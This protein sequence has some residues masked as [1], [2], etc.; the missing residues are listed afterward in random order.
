M[1][2]IHSWVQGNWFNIIQTAGIL[3]SLWLAT[4]A[5]NREAKA[6]EIQNLLTISD[7]HR[8]LWKGVYQQRELER[9]FRAD[10]DVQA[11]PV[12]V[13]EEE[14]TN[15]VMVHFL[16]GWRIA[17]AGGI[18]TLE[19]L[20]ADVRG[21]FSLPLPCAVWEKTKATRN[22]RFVRFVERALGR[23]TRR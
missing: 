2:G 19:E 23:N 6:R 12:T 3:G 13:T 1:D 22:P 8:E 9:I 15:L 10:T 16:T 20:A 14:F 5:A 18:T 17:K 4:A 11:A 21:F 7:H